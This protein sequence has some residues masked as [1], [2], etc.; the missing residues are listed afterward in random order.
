MLRSHV[1]MA[2][3]KKAT[4]KVDRT[5]LNSKKSPVPRNLGTNER[6]I[7]RRT[8]NTQRWASPCKPERGLSR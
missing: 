1:G 5:T 3:R 6:K 4:K 8:P 7:E 2:A